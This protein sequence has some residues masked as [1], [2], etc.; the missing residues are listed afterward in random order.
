MAVAVPA[1]FWSTIFNDAGA[2]VPGWLVVLANAAVA[3]L[4]AAATF[5]GLMGN[6][7]LATVLNANG[8]LFA[9]IMGFIYSDLMVPPLVAINAKYDGKRV[10][11]YIAGVMWVSIVL[12][13]TLL[14]ALFSA[15]G[16]TPE[17][18]LGGGS[19]QPLRRRLHFL[20]QPCHGGGHRTDGRVAPTVREAGAAGRDHHNHGNSLSVKRAV[21]N[22]MIA[23]SRPSAWRSVCCTMLVARV[24]ASQSPGM[25]PSSR[26]PRRQPWL[27]AAVEKRC[28]LTPLASGPERALPGLHGPGDGKQLPATATGAHRPAPGGPRELRADPQ[29]P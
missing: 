26:T 1:A 10:A 17:S 29:D 12:T 25:M 3:P 21:V 14:H 19:D 18:Q 8:V 16:I 23:G 7:P 9:G 27:I 4:V 22:P 20:A 11:L 15:V 2:S 28:R 6:I 24:T 5:I 13:A